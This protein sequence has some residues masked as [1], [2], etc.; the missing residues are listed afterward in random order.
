V[1]DTFD[2]RQAAREAPAAAVPAEADD[3]LAMAARG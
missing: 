3:L 1:W 2:R